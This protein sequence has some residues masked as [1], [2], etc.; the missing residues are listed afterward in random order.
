MG[1]SSVFSL[2]QIYRKQVTQTWSKIPQV[3]RYVNTFI[4]LNNVGY[5]AGSGSPGYQ[6]TVER[7]D[8]SNDTEIGVYVTTL[9]KYV[10]WPG[11]TGNSTHGYWGG[12]DSAPSSPNIVSTVDRLDY[13][14]DTSTSTKGPLSQARKWLVA[15][16][17]ASF[18]YFGGG[19]TG[20]DVSTVD[21][22]DYSSDTSTASPKGPLTTVKRW[23]MA[24]GDQSYGYFAGGEPSPSNPY[25]Y[26]TVDRVDYSND[27]ST[28]SPK[29][30]LTNHVYGGAAT[31]NIDYGWYAGGYGP[32][33][34]SK[35]DRIDY[36]NDTA[37]A[38][39]RGPLTS[40]KKYVAA[41]GNRSFG[42]IGG[43]GPSPNISTIDRIDYSSDTTTASPKGNLKNQRY[44]MGGVSPFSMANPTMPTPATRTESFTSAVGT[45]FGYFGGGSSNGPRHSWVQRIDFTNDTATASS[46]ASL[47]Y[48]QYRAS[49]TGNRSFGYWAGGR[50]PSAGSYPV[51]KVSRID[52]SNDSTAPSPKGALSATQDY[53]A[54][55]GTISYGY[56]GGGRY[57][58]PG[59]GDL[60]I[61]RVERIDYG[62]DT[63]TATVKG[64]LT[65]SVIFLSAVGNQ[66]YGYWAGGTPADT[67]VISRV[68]Y[69]NDSATASPKG[70]LTSAKFNMSGGTGNA[71]YGYYAGYSYNYS[72]VDRIDYSNDTA[73][74]S[75]KGPRSINGTAL[76][77]GGTGNQSYGYTGG[78]YPGATNTTID[79]IEYANDT[80]TASPKGNLTNGG[81]MGGAASPRASAMPLTSTISKTVDKGADGYTTLQA[82]PA[83]AYGM[84]GPNPGG[85]NNTTTVQRIDYGNDTATAVVKGPLSLDRKNQGAAG[86]ASFGYNAGGHINPGFTGTSSTDRIDY[87]SDTSTA[88]PK[89]TLTFSQAVAASV[90]NDSYGWFGGG[91]PYPIISSIDRLDFSNDT[92]TASPKGPMTSAKSSMGEAGNASYG[93]FGG[94]NGPLSTVDRIDY[95]NDSATASPKGPL[96]SAREGLA[97]FGNMNYGYMAGGYPSG[98]YSIVDRIDYSNDTATAATKGPLNEGKRFSEGTSSASGYGYAIG[99]NLGS[100]NTSGISRVEFANDTATALSKGTLSAARAYYATVSAQDGGISGT[101]TIQIPRIRWVDNVTETATSFPAGLGYWAGGYANFTGITRYDFAN[102]TSNP[103]GSLTDPKFYVAAV[104]STSHGYFAGGQAPSP[105]APT[106]Y[107]ETTS[108]D[109]LDYANDSANSSP[110][111][112]LA[113]ARNRC[114]AAGNADYGWIAG[115]YITD[116]SSVNR[117]DY[118]NDTATAPTRG[119]LSRGGSYYYWALGGVGTQDY[120]YFCGGADYTTCDR[121]DYSNDTA[122]ALARGPL[123]QKHNYMGATGNASYGYIGGGTSNDPGSPQFSTIDRLDYSNDTNTCLTRGPLSAAYKNTAATGDTTHGYWGSGET[124][125]MSPASQSRIERLNYANDTATA[126][127]RGNLLDTKYYKGATS[128]AANNNPGSS[129]PNPTAILAPVQP[130]FPYPQQLPVPVGPAY[131]YIA[132]GRTSPANVSI[133]DRI[134]FSNDTDTASPR[135]NLY[136]TTTRGAGF[137]N[138]SYGY[139]AGGF[140]SP[141]KSTVQRVDFGNDTATATL[142]GN[143]NTAMVRSSGVGNNNYGYFMGGGNPSE[144]ST[145]ERVDYSNDT[146]TASVKGSLSVAKRAS[147]S[148]G[149]QSYGYFAGGQTPSLVS[150][151]DRIDYSNDTETALAK[152]PLSSARYLMG[153]TGNASYGWWGGG[154]D[155]SEIS[156]VDR[157]D[158]SN[159]TATASP[160]GP[161]TAAKRYHGATG[162]TSYGYWCGGLVSISYYSY[163]DRVDYSNDTATA[164]PKGP[165][166][167]VRGGTDQS[168]LG[169]RI[170]ALPGQS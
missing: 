166:S 119:P 91:L 114:S 88:T 143:L 168:G 83:Y 92:A 141:A 68:D 10:K 78:G 95:S 120:G 98:P 111:G 63:A 36:S 96:S 60:N 55:T 46:R 18:G 147:G 158:Y 13:S 1:R 134:D 133:V 5:F 148:A 16:G 99:G 156:S 70:N 64:P 12:G 9:S 20:S 107:D 30:P 122:T 125:G 161:L 130:P 109:R 11:A 116:P 26:S 32:S 54:A 79:R 160:K 87:A 3:F 38:S 115:A 110:K 75:P 56:H 44:G 157:F 61:S 135:G 29:G 31:G 145:V 104:S 39:T 149:T 94:G 42:Y 82:G 6:S 162:D 103:V 117:I 86:N 100:G 28:A 24:T 66:S 124:S 136:S 159:D 74:A 67:S 154:Y 108:V 17:N 4:N 112:P 2:E 123:S 23:V 142:R 126:I 97:G 45:D 121:V 76:P 84:G 69:S 80:A 37:T 165:L 52:Y 50:D 152:G 132:G 105:I 25:R 106:P 19:N 58:T 139:V 128:A 27:S 71:D 138:I 34:T 51:S 155:G 163:V 59:S 72:T 48:S 150:S 62:N 146:A 15:A 131:G 169:G 101:P 49:A 43:G 129:I 167:G 153:A 41:T 137:S 140:P 127:V 14:S 65:N 151:T 21:R 35:V 77:G 118:S 144:V 8:F 57:Y 40:A 47:H 164:S 90:S 81:Q 93:Y 53:G 102:D 170:N 85:P 73:T 33:N 113:N 89:G 7:I 22:V